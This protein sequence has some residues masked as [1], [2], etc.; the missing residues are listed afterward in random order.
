M[1]MKKQLFF[2]ACP[3]RGLLKEFVRS[4]GRGKSCFHGWTTWFLFFGSAI[5]EMCTSNGYCLETF[6]VSKVQPLQVLLGFLLLAAP[7]RV[8]LSVFSTATL[9]CR[10]TT[11]YLSQIWSQNGF[12]YKSLLLYFSKLFTE[13][14]EHYTLLLRS[15]RTKLSKSFALFFHSFL[16]LLWLCEKITWKSWFRDFCPLKDILF[17]SLFLFNTNIRAPVGTP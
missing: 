10:S 17:I 7:I 12:R 8:F 6:H 2:I 16:R 11:F 1:S 4:Q 14:L 15:F 3:R 9:K 5:L 13:L